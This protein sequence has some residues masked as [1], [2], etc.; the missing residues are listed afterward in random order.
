MN[1]GD[2]M[3]DEQELRRIMEEHPFLHNAGYGIGIRND[4]DNLT[5]E[6]R[7]ALL[8][9]VERFAA[10]KQ[11]IAANLRPVK[12]INPIRTSYGMKH[13]AARE[14]GYITNGVFIAAMLA[15]GYRMRK[16][17]SFN[18]HFNVSEASVRAAEKR[19]NP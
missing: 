19:A 10:T 14:I 17:P 16:Y 9:S 7:A 3:T 4:P 11:W 5:P 2:M 18:P 1:L 8:S 12:Q 15:C 13:I 6:T